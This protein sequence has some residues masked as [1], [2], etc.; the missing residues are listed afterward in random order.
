MQTITKIL[1]FSVLFQIITACSTT[2]LNYKID[3]EISNMKQFANQSSLIAISV[4]DKRA[5]HDQATHDE[6]ILIP[7]QKNEVEIIKTKILDNL[8]QNNVR[9]ISNPLLADIS[10]ELHIEEFK[11]VIESELFKSKL[12]VT[13]HLRMKASK[14]GRFFE[15]LYK[16]ARTQEVANPANS[17]DVTGIVNQVLSKQL[18]AIWSDPALSQLTTKQ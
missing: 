3:P 9:I 14:N 4:I 17:N 12:K 18:S 15:K 7:G 8:K 10:L 5:N 1:L 6:S 2:S 11:V 16:M 13:S